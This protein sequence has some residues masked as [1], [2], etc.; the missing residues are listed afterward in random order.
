MSRRNATIHPTALREDCCHECGK[1]GHGILFHLFGDKSCAA[2]LCW[3]HWRLNTEILLE[4]G[5]IWRHPRETIPFV[6]TWPRPP[7]GE[8]RRSGTRT[9]DGE[10]MGINLHQTWSESAGESR[11]ESTTYGRGRSVSH[12]RSSGLSETTA[13]VSGVSG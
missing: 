1:Y 2:F 7:E 11:G 13:E 5:I 10:S 9:R 8:D 4:A 3:E 6:P 12:G